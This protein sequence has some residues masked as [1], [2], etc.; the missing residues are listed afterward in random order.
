MNK[1]ELHK[2]VEEKQ[3]NICQIVAMKNNE[4][5]YNDTWNNYVVFFYIKAINSTFYSNSSF[6]SRPY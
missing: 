2:I 4:I 6:N 1:E 3:P 5:L